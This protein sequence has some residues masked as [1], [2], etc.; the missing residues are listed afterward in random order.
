MS[1]PNIKLFLAFFVCLFEI[2]LPNPWLALWCQAGCLHI[3]EFIHSVKQLTEASIDG[4]VLEMRKLRIKC[5]HTCRMLVN[6]K[7]R[8]RA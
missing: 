2:L 3:H 7:T 4:S 5:L 8:D 1:L 6:I